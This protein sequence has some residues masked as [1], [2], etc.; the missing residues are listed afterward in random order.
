MAAIIEVRGL[1][2]TYEVG[3]EKIFALKDISFL[4]ERGE[5]IAIMGQSGSGKST[6][7]NLLGCLDTP[8]EGKYFIN[9]KEVSSLSEDELAYIRNKE[10]GF[11]FQVFHLLPRSTAL[12]NV[13]LPLVYGGIKK[14]A[15][16]QIARDALNAV[17]LSD[18]MA[19]RPNELSGGQRQRVAIARAL[20]NKPSLILADE[21]TGNLDSKTG[22]EIVAIFQ[23][24][25]RRGNT[26]IMVTHNQELANLSQRV[27]Y[28]KDG[29]IIKEERPGRAT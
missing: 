28:L 7:M 27:I 4:V 12:H 29:E 9:G 24:L 17:E 26:I 15:R 11:I 2:K 20:V 14:A 13:E 22:E 18:R 25:H 19:H 23:E 1:A 10:I 21:P 8:S 6:L 5:F 16:L 3:N